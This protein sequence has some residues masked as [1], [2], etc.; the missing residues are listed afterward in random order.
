M[1]TESVPDT[2]ETS[3][4]CPQLTPL[5]ANLPAINVLTCVIAPAVCGRYLRLGRSP[6]SCQVHQ[7]TKTRYEDP[8]M[9]LNLSSARICPGL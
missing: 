8:H 5:V 4:F 1:V 2:F 7:Q 3:E 6:S 9:T